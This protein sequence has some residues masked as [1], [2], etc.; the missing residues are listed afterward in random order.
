MKSKEGLGLRIL[1]GSTGC[2]GELLSTVRSYS[3]LPDTGLQ[4]VRIQV[5]LSLWMGAVICLGR[6]GGRRDQGPGW[7]RPLAADPAFQSENPT[8]LICLAIPMVEVQSL[9][10]SCQ[11]LIPTLHSLPQSPNM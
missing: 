4:E 6:D 10:L 3:G 11:V 5:W 2:G 8:N 9:P 1:C 7:S